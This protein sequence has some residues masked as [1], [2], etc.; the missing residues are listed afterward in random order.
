MVLVVDLGRNKMDLTYR[1]EDEI[2]Y[3]SQAQFCTVPHHPSASL[4][5]DL[6]TAHGMDLDVNGDSVDDHLERQKGQ[7]F[8]KGDIEGHF[9]RG[10]A[11]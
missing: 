9:G 11:L 8:H 10:L 3:G 4:H 1:Y 2:A 7:V 5:C 6:I